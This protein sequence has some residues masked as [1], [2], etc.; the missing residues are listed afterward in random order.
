MP[1][2]SG[3]QLPQEISGRK[4]C[5][6]NKILLY[7]AVCPRRRTLV[8]DSIRSLSTRGSSVEKDW[9]A[10]LP[11]EQDVVFRKNVKE[12]ESNYMMLSV[13]LNEALELRLCHRLGK[14]LQAVHVSSGLC[15]L[16]TAPLGGLLRALYEHAKHYG[17]I[18]NAAPL[19]PANFQGLKSQKSA[20]MSGLL[21]HVL[22]SHRLQ[23]LSKVSTLGEM[24][25][26]LGSDYRHSAA[27]LSEG[28]SVDPCRMWEAV[29]A[30][31]YDLN[32][33][34]R[35]AIVLLKSFLMVLPAD[36]LGT[37]QQTILDQSKTR[38]AGASSDH[39]VIRHRRMPSI[40]GQ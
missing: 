21:N 32:T 3:D 9:R 22:L 29:D 35:E 1:L 5:L 14:S 30:D 38:R 19:D 10:W 28:I 25:E 11:A 8:K 31:H 7:S 4:R 15:L 12:L 33:C 13:S 36:Q 34:L 27:D 26:D 2:K 23:F 39:Q 16:L 24:V 20:R 18:P 17:T 40:A 6:V 37:F